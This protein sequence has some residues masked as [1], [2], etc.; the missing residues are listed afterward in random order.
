M[1]TAC[2]AAVSKCSVFVLILHRSDALADIELLS[3]ID[4]A[5]LRR[6]RRAEDRIN[7]IIGRNLLHHLICPYNKPNSCTVE[8]GEN[9][10]PFIR[11]GPSFN[12][13]HSGSFVAIAVCSAGRV[14]I[15]IETFDHLVDSNELL[16]IVTH[17][18]ERCIVQ[19]RANELQ[20]QMMFRRCWTRKEALLKATGDGLIDDLTSINV[21]LLESHPVLHPPF[22]LRLA[23]LEDES[24]PVTAALAIEPNVNRI[25]CRFASFSEVHSII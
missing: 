25:D 19:S 22:S 5:R 20:Q 12:L 23:D 4:L 24:V 11:N 14:G 9:G 21:E 2:D 10:K 15:D 13:S 7:L 16:P 6:L 17:P 3:E 1:R 18:V 8:I